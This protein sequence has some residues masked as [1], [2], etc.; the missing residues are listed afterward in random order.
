[1]ALTPMSRV[2]NRNP[3][4][5]ETGEEA[6]PRF[7]RRSPCPK[8]DR[9]S[10]DLENPNTRPVREAG[11]DHGKCPLRPVHGAS[12]KD[13]FRDAD[14]EKFNQHGKICSVCRTHAT[15]VELDPGLM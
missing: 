13:A 10:M 4:F 9:L 1:M 5:I 3:E 2:D 6:P 14:I 8:A 7:S 12:R 11:E 15:H